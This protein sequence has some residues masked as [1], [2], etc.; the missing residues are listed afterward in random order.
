MGHS[1]GG[2]IAL[3]H[4]ALAAAGCARSSRSRSCAARRRASAARCGSPSPRAAAIARARTRSRA[5][6]SCRRRRTRASALRASIAAHSVAQEPDG[7]FGFK[8]DPRWFGLPRQPAASARRDPLSDADR[9]RS[10]EPAALRRGRRRLR[11]G[12][13][14]GAGRGDRG[15]RPQPAPRAAGGVP[16]RRPAVPA[17]AR[18]TELPAGRAALVCW[19]SREDAMAEL[20]QR[21]LTEVRRLLERRELS[22]VELMQATL[23]RIDAREPDAE[24]LRRAAR[25]R[26]A[27]RRRARRRRAHRARRGAPARG[28]PARREGS[29]GRRRPGD[30]RGLGPLQGQPGGARLRAG[31]APAR[32]RRDRGRQDQRARVR[33]HRDHQEPALRRDAQSVESRAHAGRLERRLLG[34]DRG[35]R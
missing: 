18:S 15:R 14:G 31:R 13:P 26:C 4:A 25:A 12:D 1:M 35:R 10:R 27:A 6:A 28:H 17:G 5:T 30:L 3:D 21:P 2:H 19:R 9:A 33:L 11:G 16:G 32:G 22:A 20:L 8:F 7:R 24:R 23:A 34:G 29:R